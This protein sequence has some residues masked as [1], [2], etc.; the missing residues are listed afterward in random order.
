MSEKDVPDR[1]A[2]FDEEV[3]TFTEADKERTAAQAKQSAQTQAQESEPT[4]ELDID[5]AAANEAAAADT[6]STK[7]IYAR[8]NRAQPQRIPASKPVAAPDAGADAAEPAPIDSAA[9]P[10]QVLAS[11]AVNAATASPQQAAEAEETVA[12]DASPVATTVAADDAVDPTNPT[13]DSYPETTQY[14]AEASA[15]EPYDYVAVEKHARGTIDFG[16]FVLRIMLAAW[17]ILDSVA[18]FFSLGAHA[19]VQ[20]LEDELVTQGYAEPGLLSILV[21]S[22]ELSAGVFL[23]FGVLSPLAAAVAVAVTGWNFLDALN[24]VAN[25]DFWQLDADLLVAWFLLLIAITIQ[26]TGPGRISVD[27]NRS[28]TNRPLASSWLFFIIGAAGAAALWWFGSGVN[29]IS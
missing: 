17:L 19:G 12:L 16:I 3:P 8:Y 14:P 10:T 21:P 18:I 27:S 20:G 29:P 2:D 6:D 24:A 9:E 11:P 15:E 25:V 4:Q 22:L 7:D 23:L 13:V 1:V 28:W 26:F 5:S